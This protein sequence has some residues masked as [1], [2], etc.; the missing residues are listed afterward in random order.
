MTKAQHGKNGTE[1][2]A[3]IDLLGHHGLRCAPQQ[4]ESSFGIRHGGQGAAEMGL[5]WEGHRAARQSSAAERAG[6]Q[7]LDDGEG[8]GDKAAVS[9][10]RSGGITAWARGGESWGEGGSEGG[11]GDGGQFGGGGDGALARCN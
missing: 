7:A 10:V 9:V 11:E 2:A 6:C 5:E 4:V 3:A 8:S 1:H